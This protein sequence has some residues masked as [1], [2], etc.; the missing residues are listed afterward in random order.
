MGSLQDLQATPTNI[1]L[2]YA[3]IRGKD[4]SDKQFPPVEPY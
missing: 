2:V 1:S 4:N 3:Q